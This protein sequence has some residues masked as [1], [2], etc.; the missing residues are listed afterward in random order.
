M[1]ASTIICYRINWG[2]SGCFFEGILREIRHDHEMNADKSKETARSPAALISALKQELNHV[3]QR[4]HTLEKKSNK[5]A[6][7]ITFLKNMNESLEANKEPMEREIHEL[8]QAR[9]EYGEMLK[10]NL[11]MLEER[12]RLLMIKLESDL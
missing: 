7:N 9:I 3:Q 12:V 11:P 8:Q 5:V 4:H 2:S 1:Q 10:R 6:E